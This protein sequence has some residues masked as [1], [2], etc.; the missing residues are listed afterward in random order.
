MLRCDEVTRLVASDELADAGWRKRLA[1]RFHHLMCR[2]CRRYAAQIRRL[3]TWARQH[4]AGEPE[5]PE[6]VSR[7]KSCILGKLDEP[8]D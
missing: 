1:V 3:G 8:S 5:D 2:H 6:N 7:L 4:T